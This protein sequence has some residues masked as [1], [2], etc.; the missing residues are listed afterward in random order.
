MALLQSDRVVVKHEN[1]TEYHHNITH[2]TLYYYVH[3]HYLLFIII[4]MF[5]NNV[6]FIN[7]YLF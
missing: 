4:D 2:K 6:Y 5:Y 1:K 3:L 7:N